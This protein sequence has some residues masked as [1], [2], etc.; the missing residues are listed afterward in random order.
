MTF[1]WLANIDPSLCWLGS[2]LIAF[3]GIEEGFIYS[4]TCLNDQ[5][6]CFTQVLL[7]Y[8]VLGY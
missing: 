4:K 6:S 2:P 3:K 1:R 7:Y 8:C 5:T